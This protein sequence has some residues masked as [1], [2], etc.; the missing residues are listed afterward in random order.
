MT[1]LTLVEEVFID[2]AQP[3]MSITKLRPGSS[4][5]SAWYY[6]IWGH[7]MVLPQN[8]GP[9]LIILFISILAPHDVIRIAWA[10]KQLHIPSDIFFFAHV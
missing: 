3:F 6:L 4:N 8:L 2:L 7:I 5:S 1:D 10:S 9:W